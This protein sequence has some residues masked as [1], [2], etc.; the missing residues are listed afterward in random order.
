MSIQG[1]LTSD[2]A[3]INRQKLTPDY[4]ISSLDASVM[5]CIFVLDFYS[6]EIANIEDGCW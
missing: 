6:L 1:I 4:P 2:L 5:I 3:P